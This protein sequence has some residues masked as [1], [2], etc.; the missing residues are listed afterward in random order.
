MTRPSREITGDRRSRLC[1]WLDASCGSAALSSQICELP[2]ALVFSLLLV[3]AI[4]KRVT[5]VQHLMTAGHE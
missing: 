3:E 4:K 5:T 2:A 1:C